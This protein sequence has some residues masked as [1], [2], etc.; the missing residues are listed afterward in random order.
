M[1]ARTGALARRVQPW[2]L[3]PAV[4]VGDDAAHRVVGGRRDGDGFRCWVV[5]GD[6][7]HL[8][9]A[10]EPAAVDLPQVEQR[11]A[12][13][14]DLAGDHIARGQL[15]GETSSLTVEKH[16]SLATQGFAQQQPVLG[17]H[18][19]VE[20]DQFEVRYRRAGTVGEQDPSPVDPRGFVVRSQ[21]AAMPPVAMTVARP[22]I[23]PFVRQ[24]SDAAAVMAPEAVHPPPREQLDARILER[25]QG[26]RPCDPLARGG[27][28]GV[29]YTTSGVAA[30]ESEALVEGDA[31]VDEVDDAR[32]CLLGQRAYGARATKASSGMKCVLRVKLGGV[33][34]GQGGGDTAL[35]EPAG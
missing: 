7:E 27:P 3:G 24:G 19:R 6:L 10:G 20:L 12:A 14:A 15:V 1:D 26:E 25:P 23:A 22:Q 13:L 8:H 17:E 21:S 9:Q 18:G 30:L 11:D 5:A 35:G 31:E 32:G 28:V 2:N 16:C 33:V 34:L 29:H 4:E